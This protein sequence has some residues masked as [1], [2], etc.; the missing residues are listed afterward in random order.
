M[1]YLHFQGKFE[2][3]MCYTKLLKILPSCQ[4]GSLFK[5]SKGV[6]TNLRQIP[7][8]KQHSGAL[9]IRFVKMLILS[10]NRPCVPVFLLK[11]GC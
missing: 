11:G 3:K 8:Q 10:P 5:Q 2:R 4:S 7:P 1:V 6:S 9:H